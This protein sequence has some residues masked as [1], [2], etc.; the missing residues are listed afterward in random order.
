MLFFTSCIFLVI[1]DT[2]RERK[3]YEEDGKEYHFLSREEMEEQ[4]LAQRSVESKYKIHVHSCTLVC[5][6]SS[7]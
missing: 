6:N 4:I 5:N 2:T 7:V 3:P 1:L